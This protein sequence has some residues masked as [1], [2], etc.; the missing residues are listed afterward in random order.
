[1]INTLLC[2]VL[3][4]QF[5]TWLP[6]SPPVFCAL[7]S[8]FMVTACFL[9]RGC[10]C[11]WR[12][13][14]SQEARFCFFFGKKWREPIL[15]LQ[16]PSVKTV[17]CLVQTQEG[18]LQD[19]CVAPL[20]SKGGWTPVLKQQEHVHAAALCLRLILLVLS[21]K[22]VWINL[23]LLACTFIGFTLE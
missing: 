13:F 12:F 5:K 16:N 7:L 8:F 19:L 17:C 22:Y 18:Y 2:L 14:S 20:P 21:N 15:Y 6:F 3:Q 9:Q 4:L 11:F 1:M 23:Y 10:S